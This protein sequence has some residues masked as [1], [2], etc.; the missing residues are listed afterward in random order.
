MGY[1]VKRSDGAVWAKS[2][3]HPAYFWSLDQQPQIYN[4]YHDAMQVVLRV[5]HFHTLPDLAVTAEKIDE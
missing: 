1:I 3:D 2:P 5:K 4:T